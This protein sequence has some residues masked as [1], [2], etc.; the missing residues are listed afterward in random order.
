MIKNRIHKNQET[1]VAV[2]CF[3]P[4]RAK[5]LSAPLYK[6]ILERNLQKHVKKLWS[7]TSPTCFGTS[8]REHMLQHVVVKGH[9]F[10]CI[11]NLCIKLVL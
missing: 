4:G 2:A 3:L 9:N 11:R 8:V 7:F 5:D 10:K 1:S 6:P